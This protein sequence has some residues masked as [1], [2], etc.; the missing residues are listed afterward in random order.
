M[1]T[2]TQYDSIQTSEESVHIVNKKQNKHTSVNTFIQSILPSHAKCSSF[3]DKD[4]PNCMSISILG[5]RNVGKTSIIQSI[6]S[7]EQKIDLS[8]FDD[9]YTINVPW[10][11]SY[12]DLDEEIL[13]VIMNNNAA[14]NQLYA[15]VDGI[16]VVPRNE[17]VN[18][19]TKFNIFD[20][21]PLLQT[22]FESILPAIKS[23]QCLLFVFDICDRESLRY[24]TKLLKECSEYITT[25]L[26]IIAANKND[27]KA[28]FD[29]YETSVHIS[30]ALNLAQLYN[31]QF[32]ECSAKT[33][34]NIHHIFGYFCKEH[35]K[36]NIKFR[37]K[38][39]SS[40]DNIS[41]LI[42]TGLYPD[43]IFMN[44]IYD[45]LY[46]ILVIIIS[47]LDMLSNIVVFIVLFYNSYHL[48]FVI[49]S[50]ILLSYLAQTI[51]FVTNIK[52]IKQTESCCAKCF[53]WI[54]YVFSCYFISPLLSLLTY[55]KY[56]SGM[57]IF[58]ELNNY[59]SA[60][61]KSPFYQW[62]SFKQN[63]LFGFYIQGM[64]E[65]LP[66]IYIQYSLWRGNEIPY[67]YLLSLSILISI[68][69]VAIKLF[70]LCEST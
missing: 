18:I 28:R 15:N 47:L 10:S 64:V 54:T 26:I 63:S 42:L 13:D 27:T 48:S 6:A 36:K 60:L 46:D 4:A 66:M 58:I 7:D 16:H 67:Y 17:I 69:S 56:C 33:H 8:N 19:T 59:K 1:T 37:M 44:P 29:S 51:C 41:E 38:N 62:K 65:S 34:E 53:V 21:N 39:Q 45:K 40:V 50:Q 11:F 70:F 55:L 32:I 68:A 43:H 3:S 23:S 5:Q 31:A 25:K 9:K 49:L 20:P 52:R 2:E 24:I 57:N 35:M 30:I 22:G 12:D 61:N 14:L